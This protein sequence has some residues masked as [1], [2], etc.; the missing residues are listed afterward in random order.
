MKTN[1]M[2]LHTSEHLKESQNTA[3]SLTALKEI[4]ISSLVEIRA[5]FNDQILEEHTIELGIMSAFARASV[6]ALKEIPAANASMEGD[7]IVYRDYV[8]L[9]VTVATPRVSS[10]LF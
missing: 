1:R 8:N 2:C 3:A 9:S 4:D 6:L 10:R 5:K 7:A